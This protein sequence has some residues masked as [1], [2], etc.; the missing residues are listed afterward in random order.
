MLKAALEGLKNSILASAQPI[1][2]ALHRSWGQQVINELYDAQSRGNVLANVSGTA[3]ALSPGDEVLLFRDGVAY[4]MLVT[5]IGGVGHF[6]GNWSYAA[7]VLPVDAD[8][9]GS[10]TAG[11]ILAGDEFILSPGGGDWPEGTIIKARQNT[12]TTAAHWRFI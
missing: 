6:R 5:A 9:V 2:A 7:E 8:A 3:P 1:T 10:G 4:T 11:A 12:P